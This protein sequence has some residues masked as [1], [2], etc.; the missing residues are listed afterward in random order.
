MNAIQTLRAEAQQAGN[1][2]STPQQIV[3]D[4]GSDIMIEPANADVVYVPYYNPAAVYGA[5]AYPGYDPYYFSGYPYVSGGLL[6][7]GVGVAV[8]GPLWGW[9]RWDWGHH[10][11]DIDDARYARLNGGHAPS[12]GA[13]HF[14]PDHRHGVPYTNP[15]VR[16]QYAPNNQNQRAGFRGYAAPSTEQRPSVNRVSTPSFARAPQVPEAAPQM[17]AQPE[18]RQ[19]PQQQM[20]RPEPQHVQMQQAPRSAPVFESFSRG[21]EVRQEQQR[22]AQSRAA[23]PQPAHFEAPRSSGGNNQERR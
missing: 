7:F 19:A 2:Q 13:W 14:D 9:D 23:A 4:Q 18:V 22:G 21:P 20:A 15:A 12:S 11:I 5:W 1:L 8:I 10:R 16:A 6:G 3:T 17:R